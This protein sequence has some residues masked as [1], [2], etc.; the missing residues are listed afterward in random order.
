MTATIIR[1][2]LQTAV[3]IGIVAVI[4]FSVIYVTPGDAAFIIAGDEASPAQVEQIRHELGLDRPFVVQFKD[5]GW[6]VLRGKLGTSLFSGVSVTQLIAQRV[7][8]TVSLTV[9]SLLLSILLGVP[10]GVVAAW[11]AH[12]IIDRAVMLFAVLG[13]SIPGFWLGFLLI[14]AFSVH[15]QWFPVIGFVSIFHSVPG[16][17]RSVTLPSISLAISG[18]ALIARMTRSSMLEVLSDDYVRT[19]RAKGLPER[20]VLVRHAF[21]AASLPV[22]TVIGLLLAGL[23]TGVVVIE[24]VFTIPGLGRLAVDAMTRR[25]VPVIQGVVLILGTVVVVVNLITDIAYAV[26]DPRIRY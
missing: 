15:I 6:N 12:T 17:F 21:R 25:D 8:P 9:F 18:A 3:V 24:T 20:V 23:L 7:E 26:L 22:V 10:M 14:L 11:R 19:A 2:L 4:T 5:W 1:R 16:F 13:F